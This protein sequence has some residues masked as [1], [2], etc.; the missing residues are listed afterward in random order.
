ML[1][2]TIKYNWSIGRYLG[3]AEDCQ[4]NGMD[5][6]LTVPDAVAIYLDYAREGGNGY[7][8]TPYTDG[9]QPSHGVRIHPNGSVEVVEVC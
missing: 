6:S 4:N 1:D 7:L 8:I 3:D 2:L 5:L 9:V